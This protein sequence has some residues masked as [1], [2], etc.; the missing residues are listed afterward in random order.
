MNFNVLTSDESE[1]DQW[2]E[3]FDRLGSSGIYH[4]PDYIKFLEKN[5]YKD[6]RAELVI[7]GNMDKFVY[8]PYFKRSLS[9]LHL[10][11]KCSNFDTYHDV[12][13]SWYYGGPIS[14]DSSDEK[15][16][17]SF[18]REYRSHCCDS[19]VVSEFIRFDPLVGDIRYLKDLVRQDLYTETVYVDLQKT[20]EEIWSD[21][22]GRNRTS[23]RKAQKN[24]IEIVKDESETNIKTFT[25]IYQSEMKRKKAS[26]RFWFESDFFLKMK[27]KLGDKFNL[28]LIKYK[29]EFIGG[30]ICLRQ[31]GVAHDFLA[32]SYSKYWKYQPNNLLLYEQIKWCQQHGDR[33]YDL[34]GGRPDVFNFKAA[35]SKNRGRFTTASI[36]YNQQIYDELVKASP[37][38]TDGFFPLYRSIEA[39]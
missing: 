25:K 13:S 28:F 30:G 20:D 7:Y 37:I 9:A 15:M 10:N 14:N 17:K 32:A 5:F 29:E 3:Y 35:F 34:Q 39:L 18:L 23:I 31:A 8:Y 4:S 38:T 26:S 16:M 33:I 2:W 22:E 11:S 24:G 6:S 19:N 21:F 27:N 12:I 36:I 1:M